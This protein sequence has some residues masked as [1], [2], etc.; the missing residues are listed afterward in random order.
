ML[1]T[2]KEILGELNRLTDWEFID[3]KIVKF[4]GKDYI[5]KLFSPKEKNFENYLPLAVSAIWGIAE[6]VDHH[7]DILV[8]YSGIKITLFT[9]D[10]SGVTLKDINFA[11]DLHSVL[12]AL[13]LSINSSHPKNLLDIKDDE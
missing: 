12:C 8:T 7:P 2:K 3:S 5:E 11:H 10:E 1:L 4:I 9:H 6:K 13:D